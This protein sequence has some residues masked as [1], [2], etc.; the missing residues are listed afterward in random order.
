M[1][2]DLEHEDLISIIKTADDSGLDE[3]CKDI[4]EFLIQK[5]SKTG[6]HLASNLGVVELTVAMH[7]VY[8]SP[9]DKLIYD[10]GHQ[11]YVHKILTGRADQFDTLRKFKGLSGFPK[12]YESV[13]D[14][15]DTG[16]SS[17]SLGAAAGYAVARNLR[18]EDN[19]V[20]ALIGDGAMTGG[21]VYEALN[22]IGSSRL[23][24]RIIL[25]D[26]GMSIAHNVG[27]MSKHLQGLRSSSN[28]I[29][30][31]KSVRNSLNKVP[32]IGK[33]ISNGISRIKSR[34]KLSV[35]DQQGILFEELGIKY[36]G[37]VDGYNI[38]RLTEAFN[39]ANA[40]DGP[41]LVH[42]ITTKGKGYSWSEKYPKKFHGVGPFSVDD[43][44]ILSSNSSLPELSFSEVF[45]IKLLELAKEDERIVAITAAMGSATGLGSFY[46]EFPNRFFDV[47]IAEQHAALFAAGLAKAGMVPVAPIYSSFLQRAYDQIIEDICIQNQHVVFGVDRA[48]LVGADGETHHGVFDLSY[49]SSIPNMTVFAP[50]DGTQLEEM[51]EYAVKDMSSP[52]AIRYPRG[53]AE[54]EHL[55]LK[56]FSGNNI[57]LSTGTDIT[58]LAVGS[59][60]DTALEAARELMSKGYSVG[61][62]NVCVVSPFEV[63]LTD[64]DTKLVITIEDN[65]I[66]GGFGE[67]FASSALKKRHRYGLITLGVP[68]AFIEQ[69]SVKQ[70]H[71]ECGMTA[72]DIVKGATEYFERKA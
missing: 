1:K 20:V 36:I 58:I 44:N 66:R 22:N 45:G 40:V 23:K 49:L 37:P 4:R 43:G 7:K 38:P 2:Y 59:M 47:G 56:P 41:T 33:P 14:A 6:G 18:G 19:E 46:E 50:A 8:D 52:V 15:Y 27:A 39:A 26:N 69:G 53:S 54:F 9:R 55:K 12:A 5:V 51:L 3:L 62:T 63:T 72:I 13:H 29:N 34:I 65:V 67:A 28:Y 61:V 21:L 24:V 70:L 11:T 30:A 16:H 35:L 71:I 48:G 64:L 31:K 32:L 17:T 57:K 68:D 10:V 60:L 42:V 25:N